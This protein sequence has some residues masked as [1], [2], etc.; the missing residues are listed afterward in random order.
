MRDIIF[1]SLE[2][3]DDVWRRNQF[4]CS[5]LARRY[6]AMKILFVG[7][8]FNVSHHL[9]HGSLR[10]LRGPMSWTVPG[11]P[12]ITVIH[13]LKLF[14]DSLSTGRK[15]NEWIARFQIQ[16]LARRLGIAD[17]ILWLNPHSSV[18]MTRTM[19]EHC[20]IYDITDDWTLQPSLSS[21]ERRIA[22]EQDRALCERAD[23]V[24]VCSEALLKSRRH[25]SQSIAL[26]PNGVDVKHYESVQTRPES[27]SWTAPVFGY[28]GTLHSERTDARLIIDLAR[29]FPNGSVLLI[30]PDHWTGTDRK[31]IAAERNIHMH[32]AVP[33]SKIPELMAQFDVCI[34]PH[35]ET[36]FT[37]S[38]NPI[39]LWEYLASG[40]PIVATNIAGFRDYAH[41]CRIASGSDAFVAACSAALTD[42]DNLSSKRISEARH[43]TWDARVDA[44]LTILEDLRWISPDRPVGAIPSPDNQQVGAGNNYPDTGR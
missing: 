31:L 44:L 36:K 43:H 27:R 4:L 1:V 8:S 23:L 21:S 15:I 35:V 6:P 41:F 26:I 17:A 39:K 19:G 34:V 16:R 5:T 18:H 24:V 32:G 11:F 28:T 37:D 25:L 29:A 20:V 12:N 14:P 42:R 10:K 30:G 9:L 38:L 22:E 33:Y 2:N 7:L 3:W 13:T 40:K